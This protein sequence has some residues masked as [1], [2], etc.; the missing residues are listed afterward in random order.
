MVSPM[1]CILCDC[2]AKSQQRP[3]PSALC[4]SEQ[5][6]IADTLQTE[7]SHYAIQ[8]DALVD[9]TFLQQRKRQLDVNNKQVR[10]PVFVPE[11]TV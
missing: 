1:H 4:M 5:D 7:G 6:D 2:R 3:T 9:Q 11:P 8:E 10:A